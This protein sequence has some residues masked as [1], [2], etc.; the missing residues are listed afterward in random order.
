MEPGLST[1][2]HPLARAHR[3]R[4]AHPRSHRPCHGAARRLGGEGSARSAARGGKLSPHASLGLSPMSGIAVVI[5]CYRVARQV[6]G[7]IAR[8]GPEVD[9]ILR[10]TMPVPK[11][12]AMRSSANAAILACACYAMK[13]IS[14]WA[15]RP[16]PATRPRSP[17]API[18]S[19]SSA[20]MGRWTLRSSRGSCVRS[21]RAAPITSRATASTG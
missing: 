21:A 14:G 11:A 8:I 2:C 17:L 3:L 13:R 12:R 9:W 5:P 19:S 15:A 4:C 16:S 7:V 20:A 10:S 1:L 6:L 18:S